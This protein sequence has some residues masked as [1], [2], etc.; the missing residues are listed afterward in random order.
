MH[1]WLLL[2]RCEFALI[3]LLLQ[4]C[5]FALIWL[6]LQRC[7]FALIWL[8]ATVLCCTHLVKL[9]LPA[10]AGFLADTFLWCLSRQCNWRCFA[11]L[12]CVRAAMEG[13]S[14]ALLN[15]RLWCS[16]HIGGAWSHL[17]STQQQGAQLMLTVWSLKSN[18]FDS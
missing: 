6:L 16:K 14:E 15:G 17:L 3:W 8:H 18:R 1:T 2:Q 9:F 5:E 12:E 4:R 7:E 13:G 10:A 11:V